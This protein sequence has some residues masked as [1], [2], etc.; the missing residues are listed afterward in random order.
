MDPLGVTSKWTAAARARESQRS[1]RLFFDPYASAL[2]G[3]EGFRLL[4]DMEQAGCPR[5]YLAIRTR[6]FDDFVVASSQLVRQ[7]VIL[8]AG[9][10]MRAFR[11][12]W[13]PRTTVFELDRGEVLAHK[14]GILHEMGA[15]PSCNRWAVRADLNGSWPA[16]L[17]EA[18]FD[19]GAPGVFLIEGLT[20]YLDLDGVTSLLAALGTVAKPG[21]RL[22]VDFAGQSFLTASSAFLSR[23]SDHGIPWRFGTDD[24]GPILERFGWH[25][26]VTIPGA[27][28]AN[29]GR[30]PSA[31]ASRPEV[32]R[33][34]LVRATFHRPPLAD[35]ESA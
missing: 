2:A 14:N 18:G 6:W 11:L 1:D 9:M 27:P 26:T 5:S 7:I 23:L 32:P 34:F 25:A 21:S 29:W 35:E 17:L 8:A 30:L 13:P 12:S 10:D 33:S 15:R 3:A 4:D 20:P 24:P 28:D 19:A 31:P 16:A 22:G